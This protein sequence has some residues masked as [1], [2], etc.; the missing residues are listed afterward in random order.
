MDPLTGRWPSRDPKEEDG[1]LNLYGFVSNNAASLVDYLGLKLTKYTTDIETIDFSEDSSLPEGVDGQCNA[2]WPQQIGF[3]NKAHSNVDHAPWAGCG[4]YIG[5]ELKITL[6]NRKDQLTTIGRDNIT[7]ER[8]ERKHALSYK[9]AWDEL[10]QEVDWIWEGVHR[11]I[12]G[13]SKA[14]KYR[15][16]AD[17]AS[18]YYYLKVRLQEIDYDRFTLRPGDM[19]SAYAQRVLAILQQIEPRYADATEK[20]NQ[21]KTAVQGL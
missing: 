13:R 6:V 21:A 19:N 3:M 16:Y 15:N 9:K 18:V 5:G 4:V 2:I 14:E 20:Y 1:G 7:I 8:H 12:G 10:R 17:A 11:G